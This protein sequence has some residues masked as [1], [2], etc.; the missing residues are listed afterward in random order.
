[1]SGIIGYI[2]MRE[3][4]PVLIHGLNCFEFR[5]Y[6]SVGVLT[7]NNEN[8]DVRKYAGK[9]ANFKE[10]NDDNQPQGNIG[11]AHS[12]WATH[13]MADEKNA[14]PH[15]S[16]SGRLAIVHKGIVEN[17]AS[18]KEKLIKDGFEFKSET[19]SEVL[20]NWI[21]HIL[22]NSENSLQESIQIALNQ[23]V[24][25]YSL[26]LI[27]KEENAIYTARKGAQL[28][29][30]VGDNEEEYMVTT[31]TSP[32]GGYTSQVIYMEEEDVYRLSPGEKI[33]LLNLDN[34][35]KSPVIEIFEEELQAIE[36]DGVEHFMLKEIYEQPK[37][38][39]D[40]YR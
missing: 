40:S 24:G 14:H 28:L 15:I 4:Y 10:K 1:M 35:K 17:Y 37:A 2:G 23:I 13:G 22:N 12:R 39:I 21:E 8:F 5:G 29:I 31:D 16:H 38:I 20:V 11:I 27:D 18:L 36:K 9:L 25:A 7:L 33:N 19:D 6:D 26:I 34:L 32:L 30:G 3:A